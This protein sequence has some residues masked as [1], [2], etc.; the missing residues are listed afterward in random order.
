MIYYKGVA[1][2]ST[3]GTA[4][5]STRARVSTRVLRFTPKVRQIAALLAPA[6]RAARMASSCSAL[7]ARGRPPFSPPL[8]GR[9]PGHD[10]FLG[11]GPFILRQRAEETEQEGPVRRGRIHLF[12]QGTKRHALNLE[13]EDNLQEMRERTAQAVQFPDDQAIAG[14]DIGE[15]L[16]EPR[17]IIPRA[18]GLVGKQLPGIHTSR[19]Q[20]IA[21]QVGRLTIV[22]TGD[23]HIADEHRRKTPHYTLSYILINPMVFF[24]QTMAGFCVAVK[25]AR[26]SVG[27]QVFFV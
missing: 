19:E 18:A 26:H 17:A 10:P 3:R 15:G 27:K 8:G 11:Q 14:V 6:R 2:P 20:G 13:G 21:L 9:Q 4:E 12:G 5:T 24:A 25:G 22:L 1:R 16:L 23:P 7:M